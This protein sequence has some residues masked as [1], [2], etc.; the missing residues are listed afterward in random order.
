[1]NFKNKKITLIVASLLLLSI[2]GV[3]YFGVF[4]LGANF[5]SFLLILAV[6]GLVLAI[7]G[8]TRVYDPKRDE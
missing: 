8:L 2:Y 6:V 7:D 4:S 5:Y 3:Q 1:M